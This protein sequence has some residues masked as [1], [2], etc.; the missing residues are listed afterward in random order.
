MRPNLVIIGATKSGTSSLHNY[1]SLHPQISMSSTKELDYFILE[2]NWSK[3][4]EWYKSCFTFNT[5]TKILGESSPNYTACHMFDG[6]P[7]KMHST[8]PDAKLIYILRDPIDR[9]VSHYVHNYR[10]R[11]ENKTIIQVLT[12][13]ENNPYVL[14]S[15]YHFQLKRYLDYYS[16]SNILILTLDDLS[17]QRQ[18]TLKKVF[19]FLNVDDSFHH[20][21]FSNILYTSRGKRRASRV[22]VLLSKI[23]G[24]N[25]IKSL[26][27]PYLASIYRSLSSSQVTKPLLNPELKQALIDV[28]KDD[29]DRLREYTGNDF[30]AWRL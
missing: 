18:Q 24:E 21:G 27:P 29:I 10:R 2:K 16:R 23:P 6:V 19:R 4:I 12:D 8:L 14:W 30:E 13:L 5:E 25:R 3:G 28:L 9:I 26:L 1:L 20:Q 7:E 17:K 22:G 11:V 15:K